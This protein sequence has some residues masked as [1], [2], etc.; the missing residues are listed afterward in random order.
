MAFQR[1]KPAAIGV[2]ASLPGFIEPALATS[3]EKVPSGERWIH[4]IKFDGYRVQVHLANETAKI[5]TRRGHD[6]THRFKKVAHDAWRIK[7]NSAVVDGEIVVP[8]AD[9]STDFSVLQNELKGKSKSIVLVAFD[10]LYL[11]GRDIRKLPLFRRK[12]ELK[13]ILNGTDIQFSESFEI[14]GREMFAHACKLGLEGVISKVRD[15]AYPTGRT[16]D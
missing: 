6:W 5:F 2:K 12:A 10:L 1:K 14:D 16:N 9:G 7:A 8:A 15:G 3:I 4:E 11:N 13:K